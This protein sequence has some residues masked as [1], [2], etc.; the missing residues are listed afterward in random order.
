MDNEDLIK[1]RV[2]DIWEQRCRSELWDYGR[3][4]TKDGDY[5]QALY[6]IRE[7]QKCGLEK[8]NHE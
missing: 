7:E 5:Y 6:E 1:K 8:S 2:Y 4:G 3:R